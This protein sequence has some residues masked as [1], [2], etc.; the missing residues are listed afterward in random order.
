M[1]KGYNTTGTTLVKIRAV[2][3]GDKSGYLRV[4]NSSTYQD[5]SFVPKE[6]TRKNPDGGYKYASNKLAR[7]I[8]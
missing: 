5:P 6:R 8:A 1:N 3:P 2:K 7:N 4:T